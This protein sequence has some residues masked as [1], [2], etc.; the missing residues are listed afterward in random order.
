M[1]AKKTI[2]IVVIVTIIALFIGFSIRADA[3]KGGGPSDGNGNGSDNGSDNGDSAGP[4]GPVGFTDGGV[5]YWEPYNPKEDYC[6]SWIEHFHGR[7]LFFD[8][9][10][11]GDWWDKEKECNGIWK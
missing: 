11:L 4:A 1:D 9:I 5:G 3:C 10:G 8:F 2:I 6:D 7:N